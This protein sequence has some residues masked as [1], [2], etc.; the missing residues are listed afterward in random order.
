V[1][2]LFNTC[3]V[4]TQTPLWK[5]TEVVKGDKEVVFQKNKLGMIKTDLEVQIEK[6]RI[7]KQKMEEQLRKERELEEQKKNE[8]EWQ[9]YILTFYTSMNSENGYGSITSQGKKLSRGGVANNII[10][11]NTKI[12]LDKWGE[13]TV[14]DK[15]SN[16][17][18]S[19][20][21]RLDV[22]VEREVGES[23]SQYLR[24]VNSYG[25]QRVRGYIIK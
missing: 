13:V 20:D 17:H 3:N 11:Q 23:D 24:R 7:E 2:L 22:F 1:S 25:V 10:P 5:A 6:D 18:F 21:N 14:N 15:G 4:N 8:P 16:K 9:E 19:V 12:Y